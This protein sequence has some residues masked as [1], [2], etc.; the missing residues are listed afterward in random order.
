[1]R[2]LLQRSRKIA[3]G[4]AAAALLVPAANAWAQPACEWLNSA[5]AATLLGGLP[6]VK[7]LSANDEDTMCSFT[8]QQGSSRAE[9]RLTITPAAHAARDAATRTRDC[10]GS[11][12]PLRGIGNDASRCDLRQTHGLH[13]EQITS[14]VR[15]RTFTLQWMQTT[16]PS[17]PAA[18]ALQSEQFERLA[19]M[20][21]GN[22]F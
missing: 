10:M 15:D 4:L 2:I 9:L 11:S 16:R 21:A 19:R 18:R 22:L 12:M 1:M 3:C 14:R 7:T 20:I 6:E 17:S 8:H 13:V 5:S